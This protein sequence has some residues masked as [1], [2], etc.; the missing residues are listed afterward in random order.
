MKI[1]LITVLMMIA[2]PAW[3]QKMNQNAEIG[4][5]TA[6][7][8]VQ[9][10]PNQQ[11]WPAECDPS[12][13]HNRSIDNR[14]WTC[15]DNHWE[16]IASL[17][18]QS[19]TGIRILTGIGAG[20]SFGNLYFGPSLAIEL[21]VAD[22]IELDASDAFQPIEQHIALG[23]GWG[24]QV[25]AGG[26]VWMTPSIGING[27][28]EYSNYKVSISKHAEYM[29]TG[30]TYR[31]AIDQIPMRYTFDYIRQFNNGI[32]SIGTES[33]HLQ[34]GQFNLDMRVAC[35]LDFCV[36][37]AF[38][39][40]I[41]HVLTQSNPLCDG[42]FAGPVTCPRTSASSGAFSTIIALEFPRRRSNETEA[43]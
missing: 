41:G 21:P 32:D 38:D 43:F 33:A 31:K 17:T 4:P 2:I 16:P 20:S 35:H 39:F 30:L 13:D 34:A 3:A 11:E 8:Y 14:T 5:V 27:S 36:R 18:Y 23:N 10:S 15:V 19:S 24:N 28:A 42:T 26:I 6:P 37:L 29:A 1:A 9:L 22:R 7:F 25:K 12:I 40:K